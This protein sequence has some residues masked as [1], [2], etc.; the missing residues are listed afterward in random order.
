[1]TMHKPHREPVRWSRTLLAALAFATSL[2]LAAA[3]LEPGSPWPALTLPDQ[4]DRPVSV[5]PP[6]RLVLF[7][8]DKAAS[9]R[10]V[11]VLVARGAQALSAL[12]AVYVADI[13]AMPALV[14]RMFALPRLR[15]LTFPVA[16]ARDAALVS[17][18]PRQPGSV[19]VFTLREGRVAAVRQ[20]ATTEALE[21]LLKELAP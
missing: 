18:L 8:A 6:A 4:H 5:G 10:A 21:A 20:A 19:T 3:P 13:S 12:Q 17:D 7:A 16:L 2:P 9:D 11:A 1:M 15:E 14:T